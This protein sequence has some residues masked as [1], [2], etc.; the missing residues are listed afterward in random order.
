M[1]IPMKMRAG[2]GD[3][4]V[5]ISH[6]SENGL[7]KDAGGKLVPAHFIKSVTITVNGK[8]V[9]DGQT[10]GGVS[11]DPYLALKVK[12]MKPGDRIKASVED[13]KGEQGSIEQTVA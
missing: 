4:R 3:I 5:L 12:G 10:S 2:N 6:P 9:L 8:V 13:S 7:R 1:A 11:R